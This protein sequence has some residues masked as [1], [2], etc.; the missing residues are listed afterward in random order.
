MVFAIRWKQMPRWAGPLFAL[1]TMIAFVGN[2]QCAVFCFLQEFAPVPVRQTV[3]LP[4]Q[5]DE[6]SCCRHYGSPK[7]KHA[8]CPQSVSQTD[9]ALLDNH[10]WTAT[11]PAS[12]IGVDAAAPD[13]AVSI[14]LPTSGHLDP[15][16]AFKSPDKSGSSSIAVLRL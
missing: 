8:Q 15:P 9:A 11:A 16:T 14:S 4:S 5:P 3:E 1:A 13:A 7:P 10:A 12:I 2:A 6:H